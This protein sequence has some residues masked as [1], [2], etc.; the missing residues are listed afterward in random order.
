MSKINNTKSLCPTCLKVLSSSLLEMD[1][2]VIMKKTCPEHGDFEDVIWGN[3]S[4]YKRAENFLYNGDKI[5]NPR[6]KV[7]RG[8]PYDC[9]ICPEHKSHTILA[10][11][12][13]T[14]RCNLRCPIC[15]AHAGA[16]GYLYEPSKEEIR[17]IL[18]HTVRR[19]KPK[20]M[21]SPMQQWAYILVGNGNPFWIPGGTRSVDNV[22]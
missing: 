11:V 5:E 13:V 21:R 15:F 4:E 2:K 9:G 10:I 18:N 20:L 8:C 7:E 14:N 22:S 12:D 3:Y 6:T 19:T 1:G 16:A 17:K